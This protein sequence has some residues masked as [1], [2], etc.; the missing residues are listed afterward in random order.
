MRCTVKNSLTFLLR[1]A[2]YHAEQLPFTSLALELLQTVENLLFR[3]IADAAGVVQHQTGFF[4]RS[5]TAIALLQHSA[6]DF[7][8]IV[9]VHLT[10]ERLD[11][12]RLHLNLQPW[13]KCMAQPM[14][15]VAATKHPKQYK[16]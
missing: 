1:H 12:K 15:N 2:S 4:G 10:A 3:F 16:P 6:H 14:P 5:D 7:F 9:R 11:V 13:R 8:R